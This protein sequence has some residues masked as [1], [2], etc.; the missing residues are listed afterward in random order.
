MTKFFAKKLNKKGFTLAELL[1]VIA[2]IAILVAI[3]VPIFTSELEK[4]KIARDKAN[5]RALKSAGIAG[6]LDPK[7]G[8]DFDTSGSNKYY[9]SATFS[10]DGTMG[11]V[12]VT[13][14]ASAPSSGSKAEA[15]KMKYDGTTSYYVEITG[16]SIS[17]S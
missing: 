16:S 11:N 7:N 8:I 12:T 6:I 17:V 15:G 9:A 4:A 3:A 10:D 14:G 2:I 5:I 13:V 1:I